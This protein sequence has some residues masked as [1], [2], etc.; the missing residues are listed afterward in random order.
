[1]LRVDIFV[2]SVSVTVVWMYSHM[3]WVV[4]VAIVTSIWWWLSLLWMRV[5]VAVVVSSVRVD[6][7]CVVVLVGR[8][9]ISIVARNMYIGMPILQR[10][11]VSS[12]SW[13]TRSHSD[14]D[15]A[16]DMV[17]GW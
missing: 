16:R 9:P 5:F 10:F 15:G 17:R 13:T 1:M 6:H 14:P 12:S 7:R 8:D 3:A 11:P 4:F 2:S